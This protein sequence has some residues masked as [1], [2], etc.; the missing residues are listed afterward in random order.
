MAEDFDNLFLSILCSPDGY[1][2]EVAGDMLHCEE[3]GENF[4][5]INDIPR[6]GGGL[7][8]GQEQ[9][10]ETF[11][12]KWNRTP[13]WG[14][15]GETARVL[16]NWMMP[17]I[18][19]RDEQAYADYLRPRKIILD[20]GCGNGRETIRLARLNPDALVVGL[21]ISNAV[22]QA[23]KNAGDLPNIRFVQGDLC[24]PP[25]KPGSFD[26]IHSFGVLHHTPNTERAFKAL[27]PLLSE[28]GEFLFYV[29]AKKA[30][31]REFSD[32][33]LRAELK[34]MTPADAWDEMERLTLVGKALSDLKAEID[35]P[36][37]PSLGITAG[38]HDVQRLI[39]YA[40]VKCY[41]R[42]GWS[43]EENTHVNFDWF[44][45]EYSWRHTKEEVSDWLREVNLQVRDYVS[46]PAGMTFRV[47]RHG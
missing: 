46:I 19:F 3:T 43:L 38:K 6:F 45:P 15:H 22:D 13:D 29:Y 11:A 44:Y 32:D 5:I 47:G 28:I 25:F 41:W 35:V 2:V 42:D 23:A 34:K 7:E 26:Y 40:V 21:D 1:E 39:Y 10:Q 31:I 18:G 14:I 33:F 37:V 4:P 17:T 8:A 27:A 20:A 30:P 9:V 36:A 24:F 12:Y 16:T